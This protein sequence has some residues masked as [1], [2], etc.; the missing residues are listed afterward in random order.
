MGKVRALHVLGHRSGFPAGI[1]FS[2]RA[3][4]GPGLRGGAHPTPRISTG[5][6]RASETLHGIRSIYI[7]NFE[8]KVE[9][10]KLVKYCINRKISSLLELE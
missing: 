5:V 9:E 2:R 8:A 4:N 10:D 1:N 3:R 6:K 7:E